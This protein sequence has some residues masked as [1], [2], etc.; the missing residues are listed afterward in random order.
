MNTRSSDMDLIN[1]MF[2]TTYDDEIE[3]E[4]DEQYYIG[5]AHD[6]L[7]KLNDENYYTFLT[8]ILTRYHTLNDTQ[9]SNIVKYLNIKPVEKIVRVEKKSNKK[10]N[11][12]PKLNMDDS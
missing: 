11:T 2:D 1:D 8:T 6:T 12:K 10:I 3:S 4:M 7:E 9:K 5:K